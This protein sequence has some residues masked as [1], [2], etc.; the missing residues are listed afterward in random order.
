MVFEG[1][2]DEKFERRIWADAVDGTAA[3]GEPQERLALP[4]WS[5]CR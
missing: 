3:D 5:L 1:E 4:A 2:E